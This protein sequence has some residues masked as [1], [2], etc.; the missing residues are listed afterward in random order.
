[1]LGVNLF[2]TILHPALGLSDQL[3]SLLR[4]IVVNAALFLVPGAGWH[5]LAGESSRMLGMRQA[6]LV[7]T[8]MLVFFASLVIARLAGLTLTRL[9]AWNLLWAIANVGFAVAAWSGRT[10]LE[11]RTFVG[12]EWIA[13]GL[14]FCAAYLFFFWGATRVVPPQVDQDLEVLATGYGLLTRFEPL[15]LTDRHDVYF[16]AHPPLLHFV[17]GGSFLLHGQ[18]EELARYDAAS[19]RAR[20]SRQGEPF[21]PPDGVV[22]LQDDPETYRITGTEGTDYLLTSTITGAATRAAVEKVE[23][24]GIYGQYNEGPHQVEAR[25]PN[26]FFASATVALLALWVERMSRRWWWSILAAVVYATNPEVLVRSSYGGYYAIGAFASIVILLAEERWR[27]WPSL[28]QA[29]LPFFGALFA[30]ISDHKLVLLPAA[31]SLATLNTWWRQRGRPWLRLVPMTGVGFVLGICVF[32]AWGLSIAP[33]S[34]VQDHF[35]THLMDRLTHVNPLGYIGYPSPGALWIEFNAHTGYVLLPV[36][37][38]VLT[39]DWVRRTR[40]RTPYT[41]SIGTWL[42]YM[43]LT[44]TV[45]SIVDWRMTKHLVLLVLPLCL[46]LVPGAHEPRWRVTVPAATLL[47]AAVLNAWMIDGLVHDFS[48]FTVT[49]A[50]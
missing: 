3:P 27:R 9:V 46:G 32:W 1:M 2:F 14:A 29:A 31:W 37:I 13:G 5:A 36:A 20:H 28:R 7:G 8:S 30:A 15:L 4:S 18:L 12:R 43:A 39:S 41:P 35:H 16:F 34:F 26:L 38:V 33:A 48:A 11:R 47:V 23:L 40:R 17:V 24:D 19:R 42:T 21:A 6:R 49:P 25:T 44:A 45:F 50:W 10:R 22:R